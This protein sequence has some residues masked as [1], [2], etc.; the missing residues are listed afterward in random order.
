MPGGQPS[1]S[2]S[3]CLFGRE[4]EAVLC[5]GNCPVNWDLINRVIYN[6]LELVF[7]SN[8]EVQVW[9]EMNYTN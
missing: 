7:L 8:M 1:P 4:I 3:G 5:Y 2:L 9:Q 6:L